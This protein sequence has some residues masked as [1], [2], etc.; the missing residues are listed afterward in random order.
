[1]FHESL[2]NANKK[3]LLI[4]HYH[5]EK[6]EPVFGL[7]SPAISTQITPRVAT[8]ACKGR[9]ERNYADK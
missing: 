6:E 2:P 8:N 7:T 3:L 1:M 5:L 4:P 9:C